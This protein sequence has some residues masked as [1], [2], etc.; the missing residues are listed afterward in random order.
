[1]TKTDKRVY[2]RPV[3]IKVCTVEPAQ[4]GSLVLTVQTTAIPPA[5]RHTFRRSNYDITYIYWSADCP[6]ELDLRLS[7]DSKVITWCN[8]IYNRDGVRYD[9][10]VAP[11]VP[12][13]ELMLAEVLRLRMEEG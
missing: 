9:L 11:D 10:E 5:I 6:V 7:H 4:D 1:M 2:G 13:Y 12:G 3:V 8:L